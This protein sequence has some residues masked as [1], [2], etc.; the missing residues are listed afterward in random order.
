MSKPK[1]SA[2][3]LPGKDFKARALNLVPFDGA[4]LFRAFQ[5]RHP[6]PL[7]YAPSPNR[8]SDPRIKPDPADNPPDVFSTIFFGATVETCVLET[9]IRDTGVGTTGTAIPISLAY[10]KSWSVAKVDCVSPLRLLDLRG[11]GCI[12][13]KIPTDAVRAKSHVLGQLWAYA[14]HQHPDAPDGLIFSSRLNEEPN[15]AVFG[16]A[17]PQMTAISQQPLFSYRAELA[18][19]LN[20][21]EVSLI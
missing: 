21:Y 14:I 16:R 2:K 1:L 4:Q 11:D 18:A 19:I 5:T 7:G 3:D 9:V 13:N 15:L 8:F 20:D 10:M 17:M 12:K 6:D